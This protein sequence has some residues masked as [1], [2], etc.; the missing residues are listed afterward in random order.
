MSKEGSIWTYGNIEF[1]FDDNILY[2][3]FCDNF[4]IF[5]EVA[6]MLTDQWDAGKHI[7]LRKWIFEKANSLK[8]SEVM[9][10]LNQ[11]KINF[12][13]FH[14]PNLGNVVIRILKRALYPYQWKEGK[15]NDK[16]KA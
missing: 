14:N 2:L 4:S 5:D 1:H 8:C 12:S 3:I 7:D 10:I 6:G 9:S 15:R 16:I 13:L 11:N